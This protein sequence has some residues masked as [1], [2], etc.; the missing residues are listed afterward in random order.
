VTLP[1][2]GAER[3]SLSRVQMSGKSGPMVA[4]INQYV[5]DRADVSANLF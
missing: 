2:Y 4:M 3:S 1:N 5:E